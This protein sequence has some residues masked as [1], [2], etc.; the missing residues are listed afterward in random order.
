MEFDYKNVLIVG[1]GVSGKGAEEILKKLNVKYRVYDEKDKRADYN[2]LNKKIILQFDLIILSPGISVFSKEVQLAQKLNIKVVSELEFGYWFTS[3]PI[4]AITGTNGKTTTTKL[5]NSVVATTYSSNTFGNIGTP[6]SLAHST[7]LDYLVCEVSSFQMECVETFKPD[8]SIILN[9]AEDHIDRHK[10]FDNYINCKL[11]L[12]KNNTSKSITILN[13]D[14]NLLLSKTKGVNGK[15][16]YFSKYGKVK[17]VYLL[18]N[19]IYSNVNGR[20]EELFS[21]NEIEN[22]HN[23]LENT[24]ASILVGELLKVGRDKILEVLKKFEFSSH[25]LEIVY[26][27]ENVKYIDDSKSTNI[28]SA[29]HAIENVDGD[30]VLL[31][32]GKNKKLSFD[33]IFNK[34]ENRLKYVIAFGSA[35]KEILKSAKKFNYKNIIGFKKFYDAVK[36]ACS[37]N[38]SECSILMSPAC[39]SFDEF[40]NYAERGETFSKLVK[41]F[42]DVKKS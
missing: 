23:V 32:G 16:Y 26:Q 9:L 5:T 15:V 40:K 17:G 24:L 35:R 36:F 6:L 37:M 22:L 42:N 10:T 33:D 27:K 11:N 25:R 34:N 4:I 3:C 13:G 28:H 12:L 29:K 39:A 21:L 38:V 7:D 31:L 30:I 2:R 41:E 19:K 8:I 20:D 18:N 1:Y 14:D